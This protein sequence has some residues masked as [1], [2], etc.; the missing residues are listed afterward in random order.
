LAW[1]Y[2]AAAYLGEMISRIATGFAYTAS[3]ITER[4]FFSFV[5]VTDKTSELA[6]LLF[7]ISSRYGNAEMNGP[8]D[9]QCDA[10]DF[11]ETPKDKK[12]VCQYFLDT[13]Y[14]Y[15]QEEEDD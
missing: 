12:V 6:E 13:Y 10:S 5:F 8:I 15:S 3:P 7:Y 2:G 14:R 11:I 9:F 4:G 1:K